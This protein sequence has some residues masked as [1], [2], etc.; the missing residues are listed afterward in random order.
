MDAGPTHTHV[1]GVRRHQFQNL[2]PYNNNTNNKNNNNNIFLI[3][4]KYQLC[5]NRLIKNVY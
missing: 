3:L 5:I 1:T 4:I 2:T